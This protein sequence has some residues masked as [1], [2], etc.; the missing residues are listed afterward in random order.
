MS[1][2]YNVARLSCCKAVVVHEWQSAC[3]AVLSDPCMQAVEVLTNSPGALS[4]ERAKVQYL[5]VD[6]FQDSNPVQVGL[7]RLYS[8]WQYVAPKLSSK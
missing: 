1:T 2:A 6:E 4:Q 8:A 3:H 7:C 5:L